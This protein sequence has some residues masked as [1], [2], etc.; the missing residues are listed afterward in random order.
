M[1]QIVLEGNTTTDNDHIN[2]IQP[3]KLAYDMGKNC[4]KNTIHTSINSENTI[5]N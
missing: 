3:I 1:K 4:L 5:K 2:H